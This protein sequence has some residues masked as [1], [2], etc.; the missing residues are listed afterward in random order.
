MRGL[1]T[2][3]RR[4]QDAPVQGKTILVRV[5]YNVPLKK[6]QIGDDSRIVASLPTLTHLLDRDAKLVLLSHLG[7]PEGKVVPDLRLDPVAKRL[8]T[9][10]GRAVQKLDDCVGE[11]IQETV[12]RG[13]TGDLFLLENVRFHPEEATNDPEF[14]L[15][16]AQLGDLFINDAFATL[17][18]AHASTLGI[19]SYL[20][21]YAGLLL[22]KEI[23]AVSHLTDNP[24]PPYVA[25]VGG[26]KAGSKLGALRDLLDHVDTL[27]IGGGVAF[28]FLRCK[29]YPVGNS[30][31]DE[32]LLGEIKELIKE[33]YEKNVLILL[34]HDVVIAREIDAAAETAICRAEKI[35]PGWLG[36]DIGP[37]TIRRFKAKIKTAKTIVWTGPMGVFE[38][39]PFAHGT[40]AITEAL[41]DSDAFTVIGGGETGEAAVKMGWEKKI[42]Y[43]STGG[44]ACLALLGGKS[45]PAL[46]ALRV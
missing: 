38:L 1:L 36:L 10:L 41:A 18:R 39:P 9:L 7:R 8:G 42:S 44:G 37:Q 45:L 26:S 12:R 21:S 16:L 46:E 43:I 33:A 4:V 19:C 25:I 24:T 13:T 2:G 28:T 40:E 17:H 31:V 20:P 3:L 29:G 11:A 15:K 35:P 14:A 34:P 23:E 30:P 27:L 22:Q 6:G 32:S 5:D